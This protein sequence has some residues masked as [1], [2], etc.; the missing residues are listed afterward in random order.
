MNT[1]QPKAKVNCNKVCVPYIVNQNNRS[2]Q[3]KNVMLKNTTEKMKNVWNET[4]KKL[5]KLVKLP[6]ALIFN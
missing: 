6:H 4:L 3:C 5:S 2:T 1:T